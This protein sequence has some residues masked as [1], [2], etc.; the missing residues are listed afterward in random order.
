MKRVL[1]AVDGSDFATSAVRTAAEIAKGVGLKSVTLVN[2][3]PLVAGPM[4]PVFVAAPPDDIEAWEVFKEPRQVLGEAG[5]EVHLLL[6]EGDPAAEIV[7]VASEKGFDLIVVGHRG[8]SSV[9]AFLLGSVS[10]RVV[11]HAHCSVLVAR[12]DA[13]T[14]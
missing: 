3:I 9:R 2:V 4:G 12:S 8:Q 6:E 1:V 14:S 11:N 13:E 7:R 5:L 10:D